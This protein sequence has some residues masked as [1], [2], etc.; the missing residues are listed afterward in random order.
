MGQIS[1]EKVLSRKDCVI[2]MD[3][4]WGTISARAL[5]PRLMG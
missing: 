1:S 5:P 3:G 2:G 4:L